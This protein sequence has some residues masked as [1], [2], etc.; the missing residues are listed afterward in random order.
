MRY[1]SDVLA[2]RGRHLLLIKRGWDPFE[3]MWALPGGHIDPGEDAFMAAIRELLE[4]T[5]L[6][7]GSYDLREVGEF[8]TPGRDPR[9]DYH[10]TAFVVQVPEGTE[11]TAGDDAAEVGWFPLDD[12]PP[13]AFDH[14]DI[15]RAANL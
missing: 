3:G 10:T 5:N 12:L 13:L 6:K 15:V 4:E 14:A 9:G 7:V 2:V 8:S 11:A 1:T